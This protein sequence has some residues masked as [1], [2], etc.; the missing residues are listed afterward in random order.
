MAEAQIILAHSRESGLVA[1]AAGEQHPWAHTT[2]AESGFSRD[3]D[4]VWH[5]PAD[6]NGSTVVD[7]V[8]CAKRH[9][10]SVHTSSRRFIGDAARDLGRHLPGHW[11]VSVEIYS[12]PAWQEDLVP[13]IW[14]SGELGRVLQSERIPYAATLTDTVHGT[15]LLFIERPGRQ[16][17]YLVGAFAPEGLEEGY[18]DPHA[19]RS[20]VLPP[21]PGRAAQAVTDRYLPSYEQAVHAR[22]TSAIAAV[23]GGIRAEHDTWQAMVASGR[24]S[25]ASP[26]SAAAR[27]AA[28]EEFL[29]H[30]WRRFLTLVDHAPTLLDR[31]APASSPWPDDA[32]ALSRLAGAVSDA[33]SLLDELVHG[34]PVLSQERNARAWPAIETWLTDGEIFLRQ[35]RVSA[36]H[37]R[38]V[39][40]VASPAQSLSAAR[41]AHRSH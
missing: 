16:L 21:F 36:P 4:G 25:D 10:T 3:A 1:F 27:G 29:D 37:R 22:R 11:N 8:A 40:P 38:P 39:L 12:H 35:A 34:G 17:G 9:R 20:I 41:P 14:D 28:T 5:L 24:H 6:G 30:S 19:P 13:W 18:G 15:M 33:E 31:C 2:L 7:L 26:L 32:A 23:L